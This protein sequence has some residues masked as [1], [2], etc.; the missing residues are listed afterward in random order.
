LNVRIK[1]KA[2]TGDDYSS[3]WK[4]EIGAGKSPVYNRV[5]VDEGG[6]ALIRNRYGGKDFWDD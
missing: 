4:R 5:D 6:K 2:H 1:G 3:S